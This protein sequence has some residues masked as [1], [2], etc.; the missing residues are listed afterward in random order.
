M[1]EL[2]ENVLS[3][4]AW[5]GFKNG[6]RGYIFFHQAIDVEHY[7]G[8]TFQ[9]KVGKSSPLKGQVV[10]VEK[11]SRIW[12][13]AKKSEAAAGQTEEWT[14]FYEMVENYNPRNEYLI[15]VGLNEGDRATEHYF[16]RE[17]ELPPYK[18]RS[19]RK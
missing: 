7:A 18:A 11:G 14:P 1:I 3:A 6:G 4:A 15:V 5:E 19:T 16:L 2:L 10:Y 9:T 17:P 13:E 12:D 8:N